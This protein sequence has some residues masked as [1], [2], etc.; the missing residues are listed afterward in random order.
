MTNK[1][2]NTNAFHWCVYFDVNCFRYQK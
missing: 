2:N 1:S